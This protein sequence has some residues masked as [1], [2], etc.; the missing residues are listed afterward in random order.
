[1]LLKIAAVPLVIA[2][3]LALATPAPAQMALNKVVVDFSGPGAP[4]DDIKIS[5]VGNDTLFVLVE[6]FQV[7]DP[8]TKGQKRVQIRDP[9]KFGL[10]V[11]PNRFVLKPKQSKIMRI[12]VL[13]PAEDKDR[14]YRLT[15]K[16]VLGKVAANQTA[17]KIVF[18]YDVLVVVRPKGGKPEVSA[19]REG[20]SI[21]FT[22]TG[23]TSALL[24]N[25]KQCDQAGENCVASPPKR[26]YV[27][28]VWSVPLKYDTPLNYYV[29]VGTEIR[30]EQF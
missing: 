5:N 13:K 2:A 28:N 22:N 9:G 7:I 12:V 25:G 21:T 27:G 6:P 4:R 16:P 26:L 29:T 17:V 30:Q 11:T 20:K 14:I 19:K 24:S 15:V 18:G 23:T 1:M 3:A 8:G 10:L